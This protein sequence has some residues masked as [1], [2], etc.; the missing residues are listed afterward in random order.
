MNRSLDSILVLLLVGAIVIGGTVVAQTELSPFSGK[1]I[2]GFEKPTE[3]KVAL[4]RRMISLKRFQDATDLLEAVYEK[5][6]KNGLVQNLLRSCYDQLQAYGK[7]E[8]LARRMLEN[9]PTSIGHQ[10]YL[11]ELLVKLDRKDEALETYGQVAETVRDLDPTRSLILIRSLIKSGLDTEAVELIDRTRL[12]KAEATLF[13]IERGSLLERQREY[14]L[15]TDEYLA[16][17][18]ADSSAYAGQAEKRLMAMLDFEESSEPVEAVL[19]ARA[20]S[21]SSVRTMRV[22]SDHYLKAERFAEAFALVLKEDSLDGQTGF[23]LV[24][25][26]RR[27]QER[28]SWPQVVQMARIVLDRFPDGPF[29]AEV[30]FDYA[31]ALAELDRAPEAAT[32]YSSLFEKTPLEQTKADALYGLGVLYYQFLGDYDQAIVYFDSVVHHYPRGRGYLYARKATPICHLHQG[33]LEEAR[34]KFSDLSQSR[35]PGEM[36]EEVNYMLGLVSF[37]DK[38]FDSAETAFRRLT[39]NY[40]TGFYVNDALQLILAITEAATN[41]AALEA[42]SEAR[43]LMY[44]GQV[45]AARTRY[46][47]MAD[48]ST[49]VLGDLALYQIIELELAQA[50]STAAL[51]AIER[52][53]EDYAESYYTPLGIKTKADLLSQTAD[54]QVEAR[55]LYRMLLDAYPDYP[56]V[57]EVRLK[58]RYLDQQQAVG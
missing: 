47:D 18:A 54:G 10:L 36:A 44:R 51:K 41:E 23:P 28:Q 14:R 30:A 19:K 15:A 13:A 49:T 27:C 50:D 43:Y 55:E 16:L 3:K 21:S 4:A 48:A 6:P 58:L 25:Y 9:S 57:R 22:L 11:A 26:M 56:F 12:T 35:L 17:L 5:E 45:A 39:V 53:T 20:D 31:R 46:Y 33:R 2:I 42:Y 29:R 24:S 8:L 37:F 38:Q 52:L 32:V 7:A 34:K 1:K 40:P